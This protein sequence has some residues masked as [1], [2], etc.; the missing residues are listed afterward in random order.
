MIYCF[1]IDGVLSPFSIFIIRLIFFMLTFKIDY[2][3]MVK[4]LD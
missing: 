3:N 2:V 4:E 1:D